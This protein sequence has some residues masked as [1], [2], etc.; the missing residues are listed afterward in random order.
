M[1]PKNFYNAVDS[2][3]LGIDKIKDIDTMS[4]DIADIKAELSTLSAV[5]GNVEELATSKLFNIQ[6]GDNVYS[7]GNLFKGVK[8]LRFEMTRAD[9]GEDDAFH[10]DGMRFLDPISNTML[11]FPQGTTVD[12][13]EGIYDS[14]RIL[15][16]NGT[17]E[18]GGW[19][20]NYPINFIIRIGGT[21]IDLNKYSKIGFL[22]GYYA[23]NTPDTINTYI[24]TDGEN[25]AL[26]GSA[27]GITYGAPNQI[28]YFIEFEHEIPVVTPNPSGTA[29][30]TLTSLGI[31]SDIYS[32]GG[33]GSPNVEIFE[34]EV[35]PLNGD[36]RIFPDGTSFTDIYDAIEAGKVVIIKCPGVS[37]SHKCYLRLTNIVNVSS[38]TIRYFFTTITNANGVKYHG[39]MFEMSNSLMPEFGDFT[40][41]S[42]TTST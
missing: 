20:V 25:W 24:S 17:D 23:D 34:M 28:N 33:G 6:I 4:E 36:E 2:K 1:G 35:N 40:S 31:D 12:P 22:Y 29:T 16:P 14:A 15:N 7:T 41:L 37:A 32:I 13:I 21:G 26:I 10:I 3:K 42:I 39:L 27:T 11:T 38:S 30:E 18:V 19:H 8:Y 5:N 9:G